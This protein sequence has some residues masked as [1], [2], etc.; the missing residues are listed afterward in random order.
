M[1]K[2][3]RD[4]ESEEDNEE[5]NHAS[6]KAAAIAITA[7]QEVA[8]QVKKAR[9]LVKREVNTYLA[10]VARVRSMNANAASARKARI[11]EAREEVE[12]EISMQHLHCKMSLSKRSEEARRNAKVRK[13]LAR[14]KETLIM[15]VVPAWHDHAWSTERPINTIPGFRLGGQ[16]VR[17]KAI[18]KQQAREQTRVRQRWAVK[19]TSTYPA[20]CATGTEESN[21]TEGG[22]TLGEDS[23]RIMLPP[24]SKG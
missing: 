15:G 14:R 1:A 6:A 5:R 16:G 2:K 8:A 12:E 17:S 24:D 23:D 20:W 22:H 13:A 3:K 4:P 11:K 9:E 18:Q 10:L 7:A 21:V 19:K